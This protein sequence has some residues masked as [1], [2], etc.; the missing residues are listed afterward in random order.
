MDPNSGAGRKSTWLSRILIV[1]SCNGVLPGE[2]RSWDEFVDRF[3]GLV[4]HVV[5]HTAKARGLSLPAEDREDLVADVFYAM[6]RDNLA[7]LRRFRG[8][9]S[10][11]TYLTVVRQTRCGPLPVQMATKPNVGTRPP[12]RSSGGSIGSDGCS[13]I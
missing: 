11:A 12:G 10:L 3:M 7:V 8:D 13:Q 6:V 5:D 4:L 9:S 1:D 2:A